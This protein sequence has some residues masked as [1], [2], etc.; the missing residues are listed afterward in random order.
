MNNI[1]EYKGYY[2]KIEYSAEDKVLYGKIEGINDLVSFESNNIED[3]ET[4][5]RNAVDDYLLVC[6]ELGQC[7]DK[8]YSGTFNVRIAPALH[9]S[10]A[11]KAFKEGM[12]LN[13]AVEKAINSYVE[14]YGAATTKMTQMV[15][16]FLRAA[17]SQS[18]GF[19]QASYQSS[20][21]IYNKQRMEVQ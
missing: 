18:Y 3:I 19:A 9:R 17:P 6:E 20:Y 2:A 4:E 8:A 5:F 1:I 21:G 12:T 14:G 11:I 16:W 13:G 15:D 10:I 7:P